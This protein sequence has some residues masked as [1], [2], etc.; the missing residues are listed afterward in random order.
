M[1]EKYVHFSKD[2]LHQTDNSDSVSSV[3]W[4]VFMFENMVDWDIAKHNYLQ[5]LCVKY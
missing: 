3:S 4:L 2:T 1:H 5:I